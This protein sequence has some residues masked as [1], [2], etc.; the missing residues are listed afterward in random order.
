M[1]VCFFSYWLS[2]TSDFHL[3]LLLTCL[4][5]EARVILMQRNLMTSLPCLKPFIG[6]DLYD[7]SEPL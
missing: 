3:H 4:P 5:H 6:S 7:L 1:G 2:D